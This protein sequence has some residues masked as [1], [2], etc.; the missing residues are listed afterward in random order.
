MKRFIIAACL[1][2]VLGSQVSG[3]NPSTI[4]S[5]APQPETQPQPQQK[6][7]PA[8]VRAS[9]KPASGGPIKGTPAKSPDQPSVGSVGNPKNNSG[10]AGASNVRPNYSDAVRRYHHERHD[11]NWWK[12]RFTVIVLVGGG[13]YYLESGYWCPAWGYDPANEYYD[14]DGPIYTYG[15]LLPDQVILNVQRALKQLG[16]Y[17]GGLNGSLGPALRQALAKYQEDAGLEVTGAIDAATV[18]ALGL[19]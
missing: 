15:N 16:Y 5:P 10:N 11:R 18:E 8:R 14:Y 7:K 13:Y 2:I 12:Q 19:N 3:Q 6:N 4:K 17:L 1:S 9:P